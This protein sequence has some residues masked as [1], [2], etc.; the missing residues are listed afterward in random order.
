MLNQNTKIFSS[1]DLKMMG[2]PCATHP[3]KHARHS[4]AQKVSPAQA[5]RP[6]KKIVPTFKPIPCNKLKKAP[7]ITS[8]RYFRW[9]SL[10][11][12]EKNIL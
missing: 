12:E 5:R 1:A 7:N 10:F 11:L 2:R 9:K 8:I 3:M 6:A 4:A